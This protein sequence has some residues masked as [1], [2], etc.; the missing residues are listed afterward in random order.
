MFGV[1][2]SSMG[3]AH[4]YLIRSRQTALDYQDCITNFLK[5]RA[6]GRAPSE[7]P[8]L[9]AEG[10]EFLFL[11][12]LTWQ[13]K[14]LDQNRQALDKVLCLQLP[15]YRAG[16]PTRITSRAYT[17]QELDLIVAQMSTRHSLS[18]RL[19]AATGMRASE[20]L[21]LAD[22]KEQ[23]PS[24]NRPWLDH[25]F[26]GLANCVVCT[27]RGKGGLVRQVAVPKSLYEEINALRY[28]HPVTVRDR[29]KPHSPKFDLVAGQALSQAF[30][31]A[32]QK[33]LT[34]SFGV[35]GLRHAYVQRRLI[36]L[37]QHGFT[38]LESLHACS[39]EVG[40]FREEITTQYMTPR[41]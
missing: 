23:P 17:E 35:H 29:R 26:A 28:A 3:E 12:S 37:Q 27:V 16:V 19:V 11:N 6:E 21:S 15:R 33:A 32:S 13:Q 20:L 4:R 24:P 9:R 41:N 40:H 5:F 7:G 38:L 31:R 18:A 39:Q 36:E 8:Y 14:T 1:K 2:K 30:T 34:F 10:D 22:I 25:L